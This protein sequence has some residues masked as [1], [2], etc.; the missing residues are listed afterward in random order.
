MRF[1]SS[2]IRTDVC[3]AT[4]V[5]H[6][7]FWLHIWSPPHLFVKIFRK[8]FLWLKPFT[9]FCPKSIKKHLVIYAEWQSQSTNKW[10]KYDVIFL[11]LKQVT[12]ITGKLSYTEEYEA[13]GSLWAVLK[14]IPYLFPYSWKKRLWFSAVSRNACNCIYGKYKRCSRSRHDDCSDHLYLTN[15]NSQTKFVDF[16]G[17]S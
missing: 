12:S 5:R 16:G 1:N 6:K 4:T 8:Y 9:L 14:R 17:F 2:A 13:E 11:S 10:H 15:P 3:L 7:F